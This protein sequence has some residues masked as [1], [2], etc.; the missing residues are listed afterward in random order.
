MGVDSVTTLPD[1]HLATQPDR[2]AGRV[3]P[4]R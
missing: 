1:S 2:F 4:P 3:C